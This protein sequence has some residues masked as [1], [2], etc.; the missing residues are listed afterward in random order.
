[1]QVRFAL[2]PQTDSPIARLDPR[3]RLLALL[4]A[5]VVVAI[6][7]TLESAVLALVGSLLLALLARM[8]WR[9]YVGRMLLLAV[10]LAFFVV[11]MPFLSAGDFLDGVLLAVLFAVK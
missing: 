6:L 2:P 4:L 11:P 8:P 3:W 5:M 1:M 9:W 7:K 10:P